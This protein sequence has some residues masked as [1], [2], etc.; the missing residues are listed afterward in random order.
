MKRRT[1]L[2]ALAT[3]PVIA[4][5]RPLWKVSHRDTNIALQAGAVLQRFSVSGEDSVDFQVVRFSSS[6]CALRVI[7]QDR[8]SATSLAEAMPRIGAIAGV[9][10][11]FFKPN[12]DPLGLVISQGQRA[13]TWQ[14]SSL[15]GGVVVV[16]TGKPLL[17]WRD[18]FQDSPRITE[19]LQAGP[20]L[21]NNG[22]PVTGLENKAARPRTFIAT[23]NAGQWLLGI[24]EYTTLAHLAQILALPGLVPGMEIV[25]ALNFDGGKSTALWARTAS[26]SVVSE[27][28]FGKVRNFVAILPRIR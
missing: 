24:G 20:R 26:G 21:V 19:L 6:Q 7:D 10:G 22:L 16:K 2:T 13:G 1:F 25:R 4:Q 28:E 3:S 5:S 18:E 11:G 23:D 8:A 9:N 15:L 14:K 27:A 17:L 12:F